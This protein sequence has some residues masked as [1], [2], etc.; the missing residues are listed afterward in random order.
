MHK[1]DQ[2]T[3]YRPSAQVLKQPL[4]TC[5]NVA[6]HNALHTAAAAGNVAFVNG[7][8]AA[9]ATGSDTL[10]AEDASQLGRALNIALASR[11]SMGRT[12]W[13]HAAMYGNKDTEDAGMQV[14]SALETLSA[15]MPALGAPSIDMGAVCA[16]DKHGHDCDAFSASRQPPAEQRPSGGGWTRKVKN[17]GWKL[18]SYGEALYGTERCDVDEIVVLPNWQLRD[19]HTALRPYI[20]ASKPG[21]KIVILSRFACYPSHLPQKYHYFSGRPRWS[22]AAERIGVC[23]DKASAD[24]GLWETI[25]YCR[26]K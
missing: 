14:F 11:D 12:P 26:P 5:L 1:S 25:G 22:Q 9:A 15:T 4:L 17:G 3:W 7:V 13:H 10:T 23:L 19:L 8:A 18:S 21:K 16:P 6:G 2:H 20:V 24:Q